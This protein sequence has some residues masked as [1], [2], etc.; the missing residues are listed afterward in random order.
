MELIAIHLSLYYYEM[1]SVGNK[2]YNRCSY[3]ETAFYVFVYSD[4]RTILLDMTFCPA[5][6]FMTYIWNPLCDTGF[7]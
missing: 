2:E 7:E 3:P 6:H 4:S 1:H 5:P